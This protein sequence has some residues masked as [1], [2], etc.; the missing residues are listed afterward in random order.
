MTTT[1]AT[2]FFITDT[3]STDR[4]ESKDQISYVPTSS[5]QLPWRYVK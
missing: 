5:Q 4:T 2:F 1:S 3:R